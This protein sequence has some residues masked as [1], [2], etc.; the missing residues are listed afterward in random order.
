MQGYKQKDIGKSS[1]SCVYIVYIVDSV[2]NAVI[3]LH[4]LV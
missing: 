4:N 3:L 1:W 2:Y